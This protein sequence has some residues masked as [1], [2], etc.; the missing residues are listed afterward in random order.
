MDLSNDQLDYILLEIDALA[1]QKEY[2]PY[3]LDLF[4]AGNRREEF[5][6]ILA[7]ALVKQS[8]EATQR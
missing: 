6:I 1:R 5:R 8:A 7:S 3:G 4:G 2:P